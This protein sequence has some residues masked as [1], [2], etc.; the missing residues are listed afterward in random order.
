MEKKYK[1]YKEV[2]ERYCPNID[3]NAVII[4]MVDGS[5]ETFSC[6]SSANCKND[7]CEHHKSKGK[8]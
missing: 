3:D 5:G 8:E 6:L 4:R 2:T 1:T 7:E